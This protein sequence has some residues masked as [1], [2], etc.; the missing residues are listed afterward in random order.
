MCTLNE[1]AKSAENRGGVL[2]GR[3]A[4]AVGGRRG[5]RGNSPDDLGNI[6][7]YPAF[8]KNKTRRLSLVIV[9]ENKVRR[10]RSHGGLS[11]T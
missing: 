7:G 9:V 1:S 4:G 11:V 10:D 6:R 8:K 2:R 5:G 3:G